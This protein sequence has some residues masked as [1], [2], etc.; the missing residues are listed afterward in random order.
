[1]QSSSMK[2]SVMI[3]CEHSHRELRGKSRTVVLFHYTLT[4]KQGVFTCE[5]RVKKEDVGV[6]L[7]WEG[8]EVLQTFDPTSK[9][10]R[11]WK[12]FVRS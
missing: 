8:I 6:T 9:F 12:K 7:R 5:G 10:S 11:Q 4:R 3:A 1:M 2:E